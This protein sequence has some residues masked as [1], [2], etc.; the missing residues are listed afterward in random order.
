MGRT[1][2]LTPVAILRPVKLGGVVVSRATLHNED[3]VN[4]LGLGLFQ[5]LTHNNDNIDA[6]NDKNATVMD[7][8]PN[9][10]TSPSTNT[11]VNPESNPNHWLV[12]VKRAG[13]VIPKIVSVLPPST[14]LESND[15]D[16]ITST[17]S[18]SGMNH[19][20][21]DTLSPDNTHRI[22][23]SNNN[24]VRRRYKLP[25]YCPVCRS[26]TERDILLNASSAVI[27]T[28]KINTL[29]NI[30]NNVDDDALKGSIVRCTGG[31][32]CRA[33]CLEKLHYFVSRPALD[34]AGLGPRKLE[35]LYNL[36][37]IQTYVDIFKLRAYDLNYTDISRQNNASSIIDND[38]SSSDSSNSNSII[39]DSSSNSSSSLPATTTTVPTINVNLRQLPGW[40]DKSVNN[41]LAA[42]DSKRTVPFAR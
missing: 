4:R 28:S 26:P 19:D 15:V 20:K 41:L 11:S 29:N 10:I 39:N 13:E 8:H 14:F 16:V 17:S 38:N 6:I 25:A 30:N 34:I 21:E 5:P 32:K 33:Q 35:E 3:E 24:T 42:I 1:G 31:I 18:G 2:A 23:Q 27:I 22:I 9:T 36:G 7:S 37:L 40:G 12:V